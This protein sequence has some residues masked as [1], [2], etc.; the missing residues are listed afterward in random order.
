MG[1]LPVDVPERHST[2]QVIQQAR[3]TMKPAQDHISAIPTKENL[4]DS[5]VSDRIPKSVELRS[6]MGIV[7]RFISKGTTMKKS[8]RQYLKVSIMCLPIYVVIPLGYYGFFPKSEDCPYHNHSMVPL[9]YSGIAC[10]LAFGALLTY[11]KNL[12]KYLEQ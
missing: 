12:H 4:D 11:I 6:R 9:F 10:A 1:I 5:V 3:L 7:S 8:F 2:D